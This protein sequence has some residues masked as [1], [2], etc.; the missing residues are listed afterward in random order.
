MAANK[1]LSETVLKLLKLGEPRFVNG[2][3]RKPMVSRREMNDIRK[4]MVGQ[5]E[6]WPPKKLIDRGAD[7][8]YKLTKYERGIDER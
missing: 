8:P 2:K 5:G 7:K 3:W 1:G 6:V 4:Y